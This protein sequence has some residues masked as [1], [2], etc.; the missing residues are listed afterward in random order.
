MLAGLPYV[1]GTIR[2]DL[3]RK[4]NFEEVCRLKNIKKA[5]AILKA[6]DESKVPITWHGIDEDEIINVI[7]LALGKM[8]KKEAT[9]E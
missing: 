3:K 7:A 6:L 1:N 9:N 8:E 2:I 4:L 5:K